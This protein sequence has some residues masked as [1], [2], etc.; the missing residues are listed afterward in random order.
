M[1]KG[2]VVGKL[3]LQIDGEDIAEYPQG[4]HRERYLHLVDLGLS[5]AVSL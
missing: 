1:T 3:Y 5:V 2:E 4:L